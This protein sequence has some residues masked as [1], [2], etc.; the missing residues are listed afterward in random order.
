[1]FGYYLT[2]TTLLIIYLSTAIY[3]MWFWIAPVYQ[4][5]GLLRMLFVFIG[6]FIICFL[7]SFMFFSTRKPQ[8]TPKQPSFT[9][10]SEYQDYVNS[11]TSE[12][13][14]D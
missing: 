6:T 7:T 3:A 9:D 5:H 13:I 2:K 12:T 14:H 11:I 8:A 10:D 1:M 4:M